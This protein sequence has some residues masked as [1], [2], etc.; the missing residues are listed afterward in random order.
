[1]CLQMFQRFVSDSLKRSSWTAEED[2][3]LRELV[4]KMRIGNFIPYFMEGRDPTQLVYRWNQVLDPSLKRGSWTEN[5]E[6]VRF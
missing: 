3:Q 5:M 2:E 1:M 6:L 4:Q